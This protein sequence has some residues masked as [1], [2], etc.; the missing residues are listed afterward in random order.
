MMTRETLL[1]NLDRPETK[2][3]MVLDTDAF[4]EVD[5]QFAIAYMFR[6][7]E[8]LNVKALYAAPF[9]NEKSESPKDGMEKSYDEILR[10]L[11]L[12][13]R[14][15]M[16][17][18]VYKGSDRF[19]PDEKTPVV[20]PAAEHLAELAARYTPRNPLY[21]AGIA[22]GTDVAS[23][24]L[25]NP[26]I[27]DS[28]VIVWLGGHA[29][30]W[31]DTKEFNLYQDVAA[32]RVIFG[33]GAPVVQLPCLGV[34]SAFTVSEAELR[35]W[36]LGHNRL[37]DYLARTA[38][39]EASKYADGKPWT[40]V[41]W[42]VTAVAWLLDGRFFHEQLEKSPIPEYDG[43]YAFDPSRHFIKYVSYLDRDALMDDLF[44]KLRG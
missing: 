40:R 28:I 18:S 37:C 30:H 8:K 33:C 19:L 3:D 27:I 32:A 39:G 41:I 15:D 10:L 17:G 12:T 29:H 21:V 38:I 31:R 35:K 14:T 16:S 20:S 22:A 11:P 25:L 24:I 43:H 34:V 5:D 36:L 42:D 1:K 9:L 6:N 26:K 23:A 7:P 4:N 13:G 2:I 44:K